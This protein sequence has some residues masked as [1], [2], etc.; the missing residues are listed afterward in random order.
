M[1]K[2]LA[3]RKVFVLSTILI[4]VGLVFLATAL[5]IVATTFGPIVMEEVRY[6]AKTVV[7]VA[8][9]PRE[10]TPVDT[11]FGIVIPKIGANS[12]II[13]NVDP[14]NSQQYQVA[15]TKGVALARGSATPGTKGNSFIFSHSSANF[16]EAR[17]FNSIFYLLT[18]LEPGDPIDIY[19]KGEKFTYTVTGKK[20]VE[21]GAVN[22]LNPVSAG[23]KLT[24]MTCWPPGTSLK[25]LLVFAEI[26]GN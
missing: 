12:K 10:L 18:K 9:S 17:L 20:I 22:F 26:K 24:L 21:P 6:D 14:Y 23:K 2:K 8:N 11:N 19:V 25:R 1:A 7:P 3:I 5:T 16:Y 13:P 4:V 15:L